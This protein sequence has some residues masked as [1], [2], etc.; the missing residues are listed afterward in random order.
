METC[1]Y[2]NVGKIIENLT[3]WL[4]TLSFCQVIGTTGETAKKNVFAKY[5]RNFYIFV[6]E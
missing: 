3:K 2:T 6:R 5:F 4:W 1:D